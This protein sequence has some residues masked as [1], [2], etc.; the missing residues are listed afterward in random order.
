ME[1]RASP[2]VSSGLVCRS[3]PP[4]AHLRARENPGWTP[5]FP[6]DQTPRA[7][8]SPMRKPEPRAKRIR[9]GKSARIAALFM[10]ST[11]ASRRVVPRG[12]GSAGE[13]SLDRST[14][15]P[16]APSN[17]SSPA[18]RATNEPRYAPADVPRCRFGRRAQ[19]QARPVRTHRRGPVQVE[20]EGGLTDRVRLPIWARVV[21]VVGAVQDVAEGDEEGAGPQ[22]G[23][24][25]IVV[26]H[27]A[28]G[29]EDMVPAGLV[30]G[31]AQL[32]VR[33]T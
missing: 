28:R 15:P 11:Y 25:L 13:R 14:S 33:D 21:G 1:G 6:G 31:E 32:V 20:A 9:S 24:Q 19:A 29:G 10:V 22:P 12:S 26:D 27:P 17:S 4:L 23:D 3:V 16:T 5:G 2:L 18:V 30:F 7:V 8:I